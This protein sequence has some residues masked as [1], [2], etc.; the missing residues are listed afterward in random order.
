MSRHILD[1]LMR[2]FALI[3][4]RE[5][6]IEKG[7]EVVAHFLRSRLPKE[8]VTE[9][10]GVFEG[11][12][13]SQGGAVE[14]RELTGLKRT[15]L[16]STK[17]LRTCTDINRDLQASEKALVFLRMLEFEHAMLPSNGEQDS[18]SR[19]LTDL[20]ADVFGIREGEKRCYETLVF[21]TADW[22]VMTQRYHEAF[23]I[24]DQP[25]LGGV[26]KTGLDHSHWPVFATQNPKWSLS[27]LWAQAWFNSMASHLDPQRTQ[28]FTPGST[29]RHPG[30]RPCTSWTSSAPLW[31][32]RTFLS[33][34]WKSMRSA[35][36]SITQTNK[37]CTP[38]APRQGPACWWA[39]WGPADQGNPP[40]STCW[41][42]LSLHLWRN[43]HR[44]HSG[45]R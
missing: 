36:G 44:R 30:T 38:S 14:S 28:P 32:R 42:A 43:H 7:R 33:W 4:L 9:W 6:G 40:C 34:P 37:R 11:H 26:V 13:A 41:Q 2:L 8:A 27:G 19:E 16:R 21:N 18:L 3:S 35:I 45:Y 5:E 10:L 1:A 25:Q 17:V 20:V 24:G 29:L 15:A 39:S 23:L 31:R 22:P 12:L